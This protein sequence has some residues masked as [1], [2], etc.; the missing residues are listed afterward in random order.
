MLPSSHNYAL[1]APSDGPI[2]QPV[3]DFRQLVHYK[4]IGLIREDMMYG[5]GK[6]KSGF[7]RG[8]EGLG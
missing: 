6:K 1:L 8:R 4:R 2:S 7:Y 5:K 3:M